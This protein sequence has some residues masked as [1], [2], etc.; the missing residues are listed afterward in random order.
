[1][2]EKTTKKEPL[3]KRVFAKRGEQNRSH[4]NS[5]PSSS[6][7]SSPSLTKTTSSVSRIACKVLT[8]AAAAAESNSD[9]HKSTEAIAA[10]IPEENI[11]SSYSHF[12]STK[13]LNNNI[14]SNPKETS[15]KS[16]KNSQKS[17]KSETQSF[18]SS[19]YSVAGSQ[20][21]LI[22]N[23]MDKIEKGKHLDDS[24]ASN[25][26]LPEPLDEKKIATYA[27][28]IALCVLTVVILGIAAFM[29][30]FNF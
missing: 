8:A 10:K 25:R 16:T 11:S 24:I 17:S 21:S 22:S 27:G 14:Q 12:E 15:L 28:I 13:D 1:M 2:D 30:I 3:K 29:I 4:S 19:R 23:V 9:A 18:C 6:S 7:S 26:R 5:T 20:I